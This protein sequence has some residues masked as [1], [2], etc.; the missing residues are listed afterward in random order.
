MH[1]NPSTGP[2]A[3]GGGCLTSATVGARHGVSCSQ[4]VLKPCA[5]DAQLSAIATRSARI[6]KADQADELTAC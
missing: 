5:R 3:E 6:L 4:G 1:P 2:G